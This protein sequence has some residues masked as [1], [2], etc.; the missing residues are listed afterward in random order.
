MIKI[1]SNSKTNSKR[2]ISD[3]FPNKSVLE[4][5]LS[6]ITPKEKFR[7]LC[8]SK[9]LLQ[10]YD[11]KIDDYFIPRKYQNIIKSYNKNYEDLFYK[12]LND[13]KKEKDEKGEK[14]CLYE[15]ENDM[16]KY[17]KYLTL[18]YDKIIKLSLINI[19]SM[20]IWKIDFISKV[21]E[22]LEKNIHLK[23]KL[24]YTDLKTHDIFAYICRYT[25]AINTFEIVDSSS[26]KYQYNYF[27]E[28]I[29]SIF[30]WDM[31]QKISI[32]MEDY[33]KTTKNEIIDRGEKFLIKFI[34]TIEKND[35]FDFE[36]NCDFINFYTIKRFIEKNAKYI[37]KMNI[38]NYL[39][40]DEVEIHNNSILNYFENIEEL[41]LS[42]DENNLNK[43]LYFF[44]PLF[45]KIKK[46]N[47]IINEDENQNNNET[48][49]NEKNETERRNKRKCNRN[50]DKKGNKTKTKTKNFDKD[51]I[52]YCL[53]Q[54]NLY[55]T[56]I[57]NIDID[58]EDITN[59]ENSDFEETRNID[60]KK[61]SFTTEKKQKEKKQYKK[62]G[63][64]QNCGEE[65]R[66][67]ASS[68]VSTLSNLNN[69]ES[70]TFEIKK[71]N[72]YSSDAINSLSYLINVL[73]INKNNLK[74]LEIYINNNNEKSS[75]DID[76]FT[77]IL[78]K[79]SAC[80][81]LNIFIFDCELYDEYASLFNDYFN[82]GPSLT[83]LSLVH[84][85]DLD[86]MK[87]INDH[88]N[89][90]HIRFELLSQNSKNT[91]EI[92]RNYQFDLDVNREWKSIDLTNYPV[93]QNLV[94]ILRNNKNISASLYF[95]ENISDVSEQTINEIL[96]RLCDNN[97][98]NW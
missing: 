74:Y 79:I 4:K 44:Y 63:K 51:H 83:H 23:I 37:K 28:D 9:K 48:E 17:L 90:S 24:V 12:L 66:Q 67:K 22:T 39:L 56:E 25:K 92:T 15:I 59:E 19:N 62:K 98:N 91:K 77:L 47:L 97:E 33:F 31:I 49:K 8:N 71:E 26:S 6:F 72:L 11:S 10:E 41:S 52:K 36:L 65:I 2:T 3:L 34:N 55:Y 30:N 21:L 45:P 85:P 57:P 68:F 64:R 82:I 27:T 70:L 93:N 35:E 14:V 13:I 7:L 53:D 50:K 43:L 76:D 80:K 32:N 86:I 60:M 89:L 61:F 87:I 5:I 81:N 46:F 18:K 54:L 95:Y 38:Q 88:Q 78:Q 29:V 40:K 84:S 16:V 20:E 96:D 73:E 69:C 94:N 58:L 75:I 1:S 42:I